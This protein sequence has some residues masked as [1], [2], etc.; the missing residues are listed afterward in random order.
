MLWIPEKTMCLYGD[1]PN[2]IAEEELLA[3]DNKLIT[4]VTFTQD[5]NTPRKRELAQTKIF[6]QLDDT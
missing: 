2:Q 3:T 5:K 4:M 6:D 1:M